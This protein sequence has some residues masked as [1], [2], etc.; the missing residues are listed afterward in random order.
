MTE[1]PRKK[2]GRPPTLTQR[3]M[4]FAELLIFKRGEMTPTQCAFEAGYKNRPRQNA[5]DLRNATKFPL[6][7]AYIKELEAEVREK[8]GID[9]HKHIEQLG[10][11]RNKAFQDKST[12]SSAVTSEVARGK[13][14]GIYVDRRETTNLNVEL[15]RMSYEDLIEKMSEFVNQKNSKNVTPVVES[16]ESKATKA[17]DTDSIKQPL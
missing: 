14:A 8:Y 6:V 1:K 17:P 2:L 16:V 10:K 9:F 3:Q 12:L 13:A 5:G 15:D 4:K 7:A 11:I